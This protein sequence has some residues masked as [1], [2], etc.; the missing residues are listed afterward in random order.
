MPGLAS[1]ASVIESSM[2]ELEALWIV[3]AIALAVAARKLAQGGGQ[4]AMLV[5]AGGL[6]AYALRSLLG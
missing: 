1:G 3:A 6:I 2:E 5:L 4:A